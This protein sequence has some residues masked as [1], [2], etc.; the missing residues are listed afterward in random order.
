MKQT[1]FDHEK[2]RVYQESIS[3]VAWCDDVLQRR[4]GRGAVRDQLDRAATSIPLNIA[5]GNGKL[6][7]RDRRRFLLIARGS[8]LECAACF[9]VLSAK[10]QLDAGDV[11]EG[12]TRLKN[13]VSM[14]AGLIKAMPERVGEEES[15]YEY[16]YE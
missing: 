2:L 13:I 3:F 4:P 15:E 11:E 16:E 5:E 1:V 14:L 8:A 12:K 6:P 9:D 7:G 10:G